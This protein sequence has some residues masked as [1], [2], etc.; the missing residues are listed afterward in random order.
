[1]NFVKKG[2]SLVTNLAFALLTLASCSFCP[3]APLVNATEISE[4][5]IVMD[6][7]EHKPQIPTYSITPD[8]IESFP[9]ITSGA[10]PSA[11][12]TSIPD[13]DS[14]NEHSSIL[15]G[16]IAGDI[17][18]DGYTISRLFSESPES[19]L[20]NPVSKHGPYYYYN[21]LEIRYT[22]NVE[23]IQLT[24]L[25]SFS[26]FGITLDMDREELIESFGNP[27]EYYEYPHYL[28]YPYRDSDDSRTM[29][30]HILNGTVD[31]VVEFWFDYPC[32]KAYICRCFRIS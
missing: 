21:D 2:L 30:Y 3:A 13:G 22:E 29:R 32:E 15:V 10:L 9:T 16:E 1:M 4:E 25:S 11:D 8:I 27:I 5:F 20:G 7:E 23:Q 19:I 24:V 14:C 17:C 26:I 28:G 31:Y 6:N 12:S 18:Y